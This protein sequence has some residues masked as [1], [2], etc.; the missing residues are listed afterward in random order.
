MC[1]I[2]GMTS[3]DGGQVDPGVLE[4]MN[5]TLFH[6]GPDSGGTFVD[7]VV[8]LAAR[9][10][11]I[12]DLA[13]GDQPISNEDDTIWVVQNGEIYNYREPEPSS[14]GAATDSR[15]I[16]T[17]KCSCTST[18]STDTRFVEQ[19]EGMFAVALWDGRER[20]LVL[21]RDALESSRCTTGSA[22]VPFLR[23]RAQGASCAPG[24]S[25]EL[26]LDAL[27][28]FL[29][30]SFVPAPLTIFREARKLP[31]GNVLLWE[32]GRADV[33]VEQYAAPRPVAADDL[34]QEDEEELAEELRDR[35][36]TPCGRT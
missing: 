14:S 35:C 2:C 28:A 32:E 22:E 9:R 23:L 29:A 34:R 25:R 11:A 1:G 31:P 6:R 16:A 3:L 7:R 12:I 5:E 21:A 20:K 24:F 19:L 13:G 8:G 27:D 10:L 26:D 17:P 15:L 4:A 18:R 36:G 30:F 33:R